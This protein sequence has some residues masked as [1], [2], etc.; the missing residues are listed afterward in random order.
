[1]GEGNL[2]IYNSHPMIPLKIIKLKSK[3]TLIEMGFADEETAIVIWKARV[4]TRKQLV[5]ILR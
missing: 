4:D 3:E 2:A 5:S 1:M